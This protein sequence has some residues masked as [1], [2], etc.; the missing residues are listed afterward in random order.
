M[1][2]FGTISSI[3]DE[4][5]TLHRIAD[6]PKKKLS[7]EVPRK[8]RAEQRVAQPPTPRTKITLYKP[9]IRSFPT[10]RTLLSTSPTKEWTRI[11][12]KKEANVPRKRTGPR[13]IIFPTPSPSKEDRKKLFITVAPFYPDTLFIGGEIGVVSYLQRRANHTRGRTSP[14]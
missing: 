2:F 5:G 3:A 1:F 8:T 10:R 13:Q 6:P 11:T 12:R 14:A 7:S 9:K 4:K